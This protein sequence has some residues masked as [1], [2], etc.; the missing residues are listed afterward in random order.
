MSRSYAG[1]KRELWKKVVSLALAGAMFPGCTGSDKKLTYI[2]HA[3]LQDYEDQA[4]KIEQPCVEEPTPD[5]VA[6]SQAPHTLTDRSRDEVWDLSLSEV[7]HLALSNNRILRV[8][9]DFRAA[10]SSVYSNPDGIG[11]VYDPAIR[12]SGVLFG[13][14]GVEA[15]LSQF[16][17]QF[18]TNMLWGSNSSFQNN[19]FLSGG[20]REG[21]VLNTDT[22]QFTTGLTKNLAY[23]ANISLSHN[24]NYLWSDAQAQLFPSVYTGNVLLN[25]V[26]P[27]WAGAGAEFTRIAGPLN[28]GLQGVTGV[29]QGVVISRINTDLSVVDFELNVRNML[30][31]VEDT[32][33]DLYLAYR[34][35]DTVVTAR[36]S[37][38]ESWRFAADNRGAG[39]FSDL[40]EATARETYF[41]SRATTE[42]A[43]QNLYGLETQLRRMC[44]LPSSDGRIIRPTD[45]PTLSEFVPDWHATLAEA[46]TRREELR[47]QKWNIKSLELQLTAAESLTNPQ[48]NF[49]SSYQL[50]GFG[51]NLFGDNLAPGAP[52]A[53]LQSG[54]R[55]LFDGKQT[56]YTLG[57]Q[58][59][60]P[61]GFRSALSQVRNIEL[62]L[63]K[64]RDVLATQELEIAHE[65]TTSVQ[66]LAWRYKTAQTNYT[67][68]QVAEAIVPLREDRYRTGVPNID[69]SVLQDQWQQARRRASQAEVAFYTSVIEY[70]KSLTDLNFRKGALLEIDNVHLS[71][72]PW[73]PAAYK[74]AL[75]RAWA[76]SFAIDAFDFD[77]VHTEPEEFVSDGYVG[78]VELHGV[79]VDHKSTGALVPEPE[80][81]PPAS[82]Q[83]VYDETPGDEP[84]TLPMPIEP[85]SAGTKR[86]DRAVARR[87][88]G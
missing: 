10:S 46:L 45:D 11:S 3:E 35:Y 82:S 30:K 20:L 27:L 13:G 79:P 72:G 80:P 9:G 83:K 31:D 17:T 74:D 67:R 39:K 28:T 38:L 15:A 14:K 32:Y 85:E 69:T 1:W 87:R 77:P 5:A 62:R 81:A 33:W 40:D 60:M 36:N 57:F 19:A 29:N 21:A 50:N 52:G 75:R 71:E 26:Q 78:S 70:N 49:V 65:L 55:T 48:L 68:W 54:Y 63:M 59:N 12:D 58:F 42:D 7:L 64:A 2:G 61:L 25:Y 16:D 47:K 86:P 8:R 37:F 53:N 41:E 4:I 73:T 66:N 84:A 88:A 23:G 51:N 44:G 24:W 43:L 34:T 76:R 22:G 18:T 56:G 6:G